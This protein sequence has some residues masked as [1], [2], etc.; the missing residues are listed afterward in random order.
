MRRRH[1]RLLFRFGHTGDCQ[2][3]PQ[4]RVEA[5]QGVPPASAC[6]LGSPSVLVWLTETIHSLLDVRKSLTS[7]SEK[8]FT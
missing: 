5:R 1:G 8:W 3:G 4:V 7:S 2:P 6:A